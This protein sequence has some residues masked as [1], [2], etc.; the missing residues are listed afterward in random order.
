MLPLLH[1]CF[2]IIKNGE[3]VG[4]IE[5]QH[6]VGSLRVLVWKVTN[7]LFSLLLK[8]IITDQMKQQRIMKVV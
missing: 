8:F 5:I 7:N 4:K 1:C 3:R 2:I 6:F